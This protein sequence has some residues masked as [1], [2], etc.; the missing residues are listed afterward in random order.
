MPYLTPLTQR[1]ATKNSTIN[2]EKNENMHRKKSINSKWS[3]WHK[4]LSPIN[5]TYCQDV[6]YFHILFL[7]KSWITFHTNYII[8]HTNYI[9]FHTNYKHYIL[10]GCGIFSR[11]VFT[12][13]WITLIN[14]K[15]SISEAAITSSVRVSSESGQDDELILYMMVKPYDAILSTEKNHNIL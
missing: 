13:S 11:L 10:S 2:S 12:K 1:L 5:T 15:H 6:P 3:I 8:F 7:L 4:N 14:A 9:T